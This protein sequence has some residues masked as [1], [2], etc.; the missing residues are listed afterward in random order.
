MAK[1]IKAL[2]GDITHRHIGLN[3][4]VNTCNGDLDIGNG[5]L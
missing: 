5:L 3:V 2:K 1:V 4:N